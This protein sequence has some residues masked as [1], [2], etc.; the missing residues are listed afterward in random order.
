MEPI[1][2]CLHICFMK[3]KL[4]NSDSVSSIDAGGTDRSFVSHIKSIYAYYIHGIYAIH[5]LKLSCMHIRGCQMLVGVN[6]TILLPSLFQSGLNFFYFEVP[7]GRKTYTFSSLSQLSGVTTNR[8]H[9]LTWGTKIRGEGP[10]SGD[11]YAPLLP[12]Y[13]G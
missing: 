13:L 3:S 9:V 6:S 1:F 12:T 10:K 4:S 8:G 2:K 7:I 11:A 5:S